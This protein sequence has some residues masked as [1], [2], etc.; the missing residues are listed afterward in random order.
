MKEIFEKAL[1][2]FAEQ[3]NVRLQYTGYTTEY[4]DNDGVGEEEYWVKQLIQTAAKG[5][6]FEVGGWFSHDTRDE[7]N[8]IYC[9]LALKFNG[10]LVGDCEGIQSWYNVES[11]TWDDLEWDSY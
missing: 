4:E 6:D 5:L 8:N 11:D 10:E 3:F 2:T 9:L 1:K 7:E